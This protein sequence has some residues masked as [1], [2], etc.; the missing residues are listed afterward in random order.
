MFLGKGTHRD[1]VDN[2]GVKVNGKN[3]MWRDYD[4]INVPLKFNG[5]NLLSHGG[6]KLHFPMLNATV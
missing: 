2:G 6:K 4:K 5:P 1:G 3:M